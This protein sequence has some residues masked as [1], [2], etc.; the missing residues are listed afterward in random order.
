MYPHLSCVDRW[1]R[2]NGNSPFEYQHPY[3][4]REF[5]KPCTL[6]LLAKV[7]V[8]FV[9]SG[10]CNGFQNNVY[11]ERLFPPPP[12]AL[13]HICTLSLVTL[14]GYCVSDRNSPNPPP[15]NFIDQQLD[16]LFH[17]HQQCT[18]QVITNPPTY[19]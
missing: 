8:G 11:T 16:Q 5:Y 15:L 10:W 17:I 14:H 1:S 6:K 7:L 18:L 9:E 13:T 4:V 12:H 3:L 2:T 19:M